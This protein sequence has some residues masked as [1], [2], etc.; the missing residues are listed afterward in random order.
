MMPQLTMS[1]RAW[2]WTVWTAEAG[3]GGVDVPTRVGVD[4]L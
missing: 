3:G 2:G 1:P 4:L